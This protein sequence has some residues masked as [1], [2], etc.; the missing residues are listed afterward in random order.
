MQRDAKNLT[1]IDLAVYGDHGDT[2]RRILSSPDLSDGDRAALLGSEKLPDGQIAM[3]PL[4]W[5][6]IL[7]APGAMAALL[8]HCPDPLDSMHH[9]NDRNLL[10]TLLMHSNGPSTSGA[11]QDRVIDC[12][13]LLLANER[14][15]KSA[16]DK[17]LS[18]T[19]HL[20][21]ARLI[22]ENRL[23]LQGDLSAADPNF[24][25]TFAVGPRQRIARAVLRK[26]PDILDHSIGQWMTGA[27]QLL[28]D[29][30]PATLS[31]LLREKILPRQMDEALFTLQA[32]LQ[33]LKRGSKTS[34]P[35]DGTSID[36]QR[37]AFRGVDRA[38]MHRLLADYL[39]GSEDEVVPRLIEISPG[40]GVVAPFLHRLAIRNEPVLYHRVLS[41]MKAPLSVDGY[42]RRPSD[43]A[44]DA[45]RATFN[46]I[47]ARYAAE[48]RIQ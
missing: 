44:P 19:T 32:G 23:I 41:A 21:E 14:I 4:T 33:I 22:L 2:I 25:L 10:E 8:D 37:D 12:L 45:V 46:E 7:A 29:A 18:L 9:V 6:A 5:S 36:V 26:R 11:Q 20:P 3:S 13:N 38:I 39:D 35:A 24:L 28:R 30:P 42:G 47:E 1:C 17:A 48:R 40:D 27:H 16:L 34:L 31:F 15:A 43:L